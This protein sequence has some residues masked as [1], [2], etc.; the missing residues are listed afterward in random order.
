MDP[1]IQIT[2]A[3]I[4][5]VSTTIITLVILAVL[6]RLL[7]EQQDL[8]ILSEIRL[9]REEVK[10]YSRE[11]VVNHNYII[12]DHTRNAIVG[13]VTGTVAKDGGVTK[14]RP[15]GIDSKHA[16]DRVRLLAILSDGEGAN[17]F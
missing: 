17:I 6:I 8:E 13:D 11:R 12:Y 2:I 1:L 4:G 15:F 7:P 5:G 3:A 14:F 16:G 9:L 10:A